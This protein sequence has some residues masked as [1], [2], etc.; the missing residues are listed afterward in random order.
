MTDRI[1]WELQRL[2][3]ECSSQ[4]VRAER[5]KTSTDSPGY[6]PALP[7]PRCKSAGVE[8]SELQQTDQGRGLDLAAQTDRRAWG[9][10]QTA[11]GAVCGTDPACTIG[12]PLSHL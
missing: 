3:G 10:V 1:D 5:R 7:S 8:K 4:I 9:V 11:T 12:A 2:R 6:L